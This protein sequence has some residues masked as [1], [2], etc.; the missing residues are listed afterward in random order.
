MKKAIVC[1]AAALFVCL[2]L[3]FGLFVNTGVGAATSNNAPKNI[4]FM[5]GDGMGP[6]QVNLARDEQGSSLN[7]DRMAYKGTSET[8][9]ISGAVT[10]SAAGGTALACGIKTINGYVGLD[11]RKLP[12][13]NIREFLAEKGKKTGLISTVSISDAT[14]AAFGGHN[15]N[16]KNM[17]EVSA[18]YIERKIDLI[19]GGGG[20]YFSAD[21]RNTAKNSGYTVIT[22]KSEMSAFNGSGRLLALFCDSNF[23]EYASGYPQ[24]IP[25]LAEM[26]AKG[27]D[28]LKNHKDGFFL[29]VEGGMIDLAGHANNRASNVAETLQFDKAVGIALDFARADG[30]TLVIV[31]ADHETGGLLKQ[32]SDYVYTSGS[33]TGVNVPVF[34]DGKGAENFQ[35]NMINS[36][37]KGKI[38]ALYK[39]ESAVNTT[40]SAATTTAPASTTEPAATTAPADTTAPPDTTHDENTTAGQSTTA[41]K[42]A[43]DQNTSGGSQILVIALA[44][45][46]VTVAAAAILVLTL[47][48]K[49]GK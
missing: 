34:A 31:T 15:E 35:G 29:M 21:L 26:T 47:R 22:S 3:V 20:K 25:T 44:A 49:Q 19:M 36:D 7:M 17:A 33:H 16:R 27:I 48:K 9:N 46:A 13:Q 18:E 43:T 2:L 4:I 28:L 1:R 45:G 39:E 40:A 41:V 14:P 23:P 30:N 32:G 5:I 11:H 37:F 10:D 38:V 42:G 24:Q 6:N 12:V 8:S